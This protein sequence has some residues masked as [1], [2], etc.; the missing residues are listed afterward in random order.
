LERED[1]VAILCQLD[2]RTAVEQNVFQLAGLR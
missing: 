1:T 2:T